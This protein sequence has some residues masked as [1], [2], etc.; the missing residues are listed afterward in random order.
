MPSPGSNLSYPFRIF[1]GDGSC[2]SA[3]FHPLS[4]FALL[5]LLC[6]IADFGLRLLFPKMGTIP[7][8]H[9]FLATFGLGNFLI[10]NSRGS[11]RNLTYE[12]SLDYPTQKPYPR[13]DNRCLLELL[14][15]GGDDLVKVSFR[16][17]S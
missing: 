14:V 8:A 11:P 7:V 15:I 12:R 2:Y 5:P 6:L 10:V 3:F 1:R 4:F 9:I 16:R 13:F 17:R